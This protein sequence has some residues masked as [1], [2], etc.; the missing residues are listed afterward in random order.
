MP[1]DG[2]VP[3]VGE[4]TPMR[5][6]EGPAQRKNAG[7]E[8]PAV[9]GRPD[10]PD[11]VITGRPAEAAGDAATGAAMLEPGAQ[12]AM[13]NQQ[14]ARNVA[15][16]GAET[17]KKIPVGEAT[18]IKPQVV[19]PAGSPKV[20][21]PKAEKLPV[22]E[23]T[24]I[25][26]ETAK[27][28]ESP[29]TDARLAEVERL[30]AATDSPVVRKALDERA[31]K[32]K[33]ELKDEADAEQRR[34]DAAEL[35]RTAALT[36][37]PEIKEALF[38]KAKAIEKADAIPAGKTVEGQP[39][40]KADVPKKIPTGKAKEIENATD[41]ST[42][43]KGVREE[44]SQGNEG[45]QAA[46][47]GASDSVQRSEKGKNAKG[48]ETLAD[49]GFPQLDEAFME[50]QQRAQRAA[51]PAPE[52]AVL[53]R[54]RRQTREAI[55]KGIKEGSFGKDEGE[56][57]LWALD[58]NP[59]LAR[60]L[61]FETTNGKKGD[62]ARAVYNSA[63]RIVK[64]FKDKTE[65]GSERA[66]HEILHHTER[67]MPPE[68]QRGIRRE[69][70]RALD[71]EIEK[72]KPEVADALRNVEKGIT[73][74]KDA[75]EAMKQAFK[76]GVLDRDKHYALTN[77]SEYW[78]VNASRI[79]AERFTGRNAWRT[80]AVRWVKDMVEHVKG[81]VGLRS[82]APILKALDDLLDTSKNAGVDRSTSTLK[83]AESKA[84]IADEKPTK[85]QRRAKYREATK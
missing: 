38:E 74:G 10:L 81:S 40:I 76:D 27:P 72:S 75:F 57:A 77:P 6:A 79:L 5:L 84:M 53:E 39:E 23:A 73:G 25:K 82:D 44:R 45:G 19:E 80:A 8:I 62:I 50:H 34:N 64:I 55:E 71:A 29:K 49:I 24:E 3:A 59:E 9:P 26:P 60:G 41:E 69:W 22:G 17:P 46:E 36:K 4:V 31:T 70:R 47:T 52:P 54:G 61:R 63:E 20:K 85:E 11:T 68:I 37:D 21:E 56:L 15:A 43:Q 51:E 67:M 32:I 2:L 18:D 66:A 28:A 16:A 13:R 1:T 33:K 14:T 7:S 35:R 58:K 78:A 83:T 65:G 48:D 12:L 42:K 30:K